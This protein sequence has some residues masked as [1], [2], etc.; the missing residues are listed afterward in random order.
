M[1][2]NYSVAEAPQVAESLAPISSFD[3]TI[4]HQGLNCHGFFHDAVL[5]AASAL[6]LLYLGFGAKTNVR[7]LV[8]GRSWVMISY[9]ALLWVAALLN[10]VWC[11]LQTWQCSLGKEA[12]WNHL[13]LVTTSAIL[14]LEISLVAFLLQ[15][16][17]ATGLE[18]LIHTFTIS[19]IV[20]AVD[21]IL[22]ALCVFVLK[23]PLFMNVDS[24]HKGKWTLLAI[25]E[26]VLTSV[27]GYIAFVHFSNWRE[28]LPPR[29]AF[30][31]YIM[32]M[33][34]I[35]VVELFACVL[36]LFGASF[37]CWLFGVAAVVYH[38]LYLPLLYTTFLADFFQ[39]EEFRLD[40]AYYAEMRDAGFF[41]ADWD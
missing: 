13:S 22:K 41:D 36:A 34:G 11:A 38:S 40:N 15:E 4:D 30:Y 20:V 6:F 5:V 2:F 17:Y 24:T 25:H 29:P 32:A 18:S 16:D 31:H 21:A 37:G 8:N 23:V 9:Y 19:G 35:N 7:R 27:Y 14:C 10:F 33:F 12:S 39:E 1:R 3:P 28:K 26:L